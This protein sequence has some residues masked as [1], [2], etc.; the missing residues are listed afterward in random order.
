[1]QL[2]PNVPLRSRKLTSLLGAHPPADAFRYL[3]PLFQL[4]TE[5]S[6]D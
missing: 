1:M 6:R 2:A 5:A 3:D 4:L